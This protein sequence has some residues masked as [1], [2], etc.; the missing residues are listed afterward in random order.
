MPPG[1]WRGGSL[2]QFGKVARTSSCHWR[3][4]RPSYETAVLFA[5][6]GCAAWQRASRC[7]RNRDFA[8]YARGGQRGSPMKLAIDSYC[9]HRY[10]GE[11]YPGLQHTPKRTM[12][13]WDFLRR[14]KQLGVAGVSLESCF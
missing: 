4:L 1:G 2:V 3:L 6:P 13:V 9:Y 10:F 11:V 14:A 12:T 7:N 8:D 5:E